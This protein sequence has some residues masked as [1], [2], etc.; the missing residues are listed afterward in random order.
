VQ[1][2]SFTGSRSDFDASAMPRETFP[3]PA[4]PVSAYRAFGT[5][6]VVAHVQRYAIGRLLQAYP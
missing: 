5:A 3:H 2:E 4:Q 6:P 1:L